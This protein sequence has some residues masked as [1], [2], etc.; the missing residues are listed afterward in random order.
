MEK[1]RKTNRI[2]GCARQCWFALCATALWMLCL[3]EATAQYVQAETVINFPDK[4]AV[5][6][7]EG[8]PSIAIW[9]LG[10]VLTR[11]G[12][13]IR[14]EVDKGNGDNIDVNSKISARFI[15]EPADLITD[16]MNWLSASGFQAGSEDLNADFVNPVS[17]GCRTLT[18]AGRQWR[19]PTQRELQLMWLLR[20]GIDLIYPLAKM[21]PTG[22]AKD[23]WSATE[24]EVGRAWTVDFGSDLY[25]SAPVKSSLGYVRCISD[26]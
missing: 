2:S 19:L 6:Y 11:N 4:V 15:V 1:Q 16:R 10:T 20:Q 25:V 21:T 9:P 7:A 8:I 5:V 18:T 24:K 22:G 23:Y 3:T 26:Y 13:T 17:G 14:H 12:A